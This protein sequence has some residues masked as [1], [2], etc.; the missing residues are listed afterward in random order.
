MYPWCSPWILCL[1]SVYNKKV[2]F[3]Q[4]LWYGLYNESFTHRFFHSDD[5]KELHHIGVSEL[6]I[7]G[8]LLQKLDLVIFVRPQFQCLY[9]NFHSNGWRLPY[10]LIHCPKLTRTKML[11]Y[12]ENANQ[13]RSKIVT[14]VDYKGGCVKLHTIALMMTGAFS[15]NIYSPNSSW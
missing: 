10:S 4:H 11:R 13:K 2:W 8:C 3:T 7:D 6:P 9:S 14:T 15:Q 1:Y 12:P 5:S